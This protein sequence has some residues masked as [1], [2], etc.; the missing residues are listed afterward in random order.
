M[1]K[2]RCPGLSLRASCLRSPLDSEYVSHCECRRSRLSFIDTKA[3]MGQD[4]TTV[5]T[6]YHVRLMNDRGTRKGLSRGITRRRPR[7]HGRCA[8]TRSHWQT[9]WDLTFIPL[10]HGAFLHTCC[11]HQSSGCNTSSEVEAYEVVDTKNLE[12]QH[13]MQLLSFTSKRKTQDEKTKPIQQHDETRTNISI[14]TQK[15]HMETNETVK[16]KPRVR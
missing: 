2:S 10:V 11:L 1:N 14:V 4:S 15:A 3:V 16:K 6:T 13:V 5:F 8:T 7:P 12:V 9:E